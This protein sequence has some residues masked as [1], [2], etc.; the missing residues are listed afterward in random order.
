MEMEMGPERGPPSSIELAHGPLWALASA[1]AGCTGSALAA[2]CWLLPALQA[3]RWLLALADTAYFILRLG[4]L[5][6]IRA[7][8]E[9]TSCHLFL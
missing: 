3:W 5:I 2:G 7:R 9:V 1:S 4:I 6:F 8:G